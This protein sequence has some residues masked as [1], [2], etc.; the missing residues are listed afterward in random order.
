MVNSGVYSGVHNV[1]A[2]N[3]SIS[4][5]AVSGD[6][7]D[8]IFSC[9]TSQ[10]FLFEADVNFTSVSIASCQWN[11]LYSVT[12]IFT[13]CIFASNSAA[14]I[15]QSFDTPTIIIQVTKHIRAVARG[16]KRKKEKK[17]EKKERKKRKKKKKKLTA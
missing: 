16:K 2:I 17:K 14:I 7:T 6:P 10:G 15:S 1:F 3:K 11:S 9:G 12:A 5:V 13:G 4:V 8:T